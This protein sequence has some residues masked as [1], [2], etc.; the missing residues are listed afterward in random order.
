MTVPNFDVILRNGLVVDGTGRPGFLADL[1]I[2]GDRIA[3]IGSL[4]ADNAALDVDVG[5]L[6]MPW[7]APMVCPK[8]HI[9]I[10]ACGERF[11]ECSGGMFAN[12]AF[13]RWKARFIE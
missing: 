11:R 7:S 12:G 2:T 3:K 13:Y 5:G 10:P 9:R 8:T 4:R 1:A 6:I